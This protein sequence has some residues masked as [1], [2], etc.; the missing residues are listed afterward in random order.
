ML[1]INPRQLPPPQLPQAMVKLAHPP[2]NEILQ[3]LKVGDMVYH[4]DRPTY[5]LRVISV[6]ND[7]LVRCVTVGF[8][9][10]ELFAVCELVLVKP[11]IA[12]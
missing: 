6:V 10:A 4:P 5:A 7:E 11:A 1:L 2:K 12:S 9:G 8:K 3:V